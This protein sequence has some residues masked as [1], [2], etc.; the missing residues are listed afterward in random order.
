MNHTN[1]SHKSI[2]RS[3][4]GRSGCVECVG[5]DFKKQPE[6]GANIRI[7]RV[8]SLQRAWPRIN[9]K[10]GDKS[11]ADLQT[12]FFNTS[13]WGE[14]RFA[15]VSLIGHLTTNFCNAM[16]S[17]TMK[18]IMLTIGLALAGTMTAGRADAFHGPANLGFLPF[19]FYQPYGVRYRNSVST[20]PYFALN[21]PVYYGNRYARPY[22]ASPFASP[23]LLTA[24]ASY[25]AHRAAEF[26]RPPASIGPEICNPF[27]EEMGASGKPVT[28]EVVL[29]VGSDE[30]SGQKSA[31][32]IGPV[33][34][35]PF[36]ASEEIAKDLTSPAVS[37]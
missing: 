21:P 4:N 29:A 1:N 3:S 23:P 13:H 11:F 15:P 20:P 16:I 22:G 24:P 32:A 2:N 17:A 9:V 7:S 6:L 25:Q 28:S 30:I 31:M 33:R 35:N 12:R 14:N 18:K 19:G 34:F 26:V 36:V 10:T 8:E 5:P 27:V 37:R